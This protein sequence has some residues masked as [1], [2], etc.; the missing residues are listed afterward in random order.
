MSEWTNEK[1]GIKEKKAT[2]NHIIVR[3]NT[4]LIDKK[5]H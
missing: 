1:K 5:Q 2:L 4:S 3:K